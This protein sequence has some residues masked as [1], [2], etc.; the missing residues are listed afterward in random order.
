MKTSITK[1]TDNE[2]TIE[3]KIKLTGSML[4]SEQMILEAC[5][6]VGQLATAESLK[7]FDADGSPIKIGDV[8]YT[9][10]DVVPKIYE[11]PYGE[12]EVERHVYQTP[13]G[14]K[15]FCPL[16]H[17]AKIIQSATPRF[18]KQISHK[19]ANMNAPSVCRDLL[20]NHDRKI[21]HS[22]VQAVSNF[23]GKIAQDKEPIWEYD[24]PKLN[25]EV[26]SVVISLDGAFVLMREDGYREAMVG[27][28]SLYDCEGDRLHSIYIGEAPEYGKATFQQRLEREIGRIK[29]RYPSAIYLGIA[30]GAKNNWAF[31]EKHTD[32]QLID[33]FHVTEY[34][35]QVSFAAHAGKTD[36]PKREAWL[37]ERCK[38]LK[39]EETAVKNL[40]VEM[41]KFKRKKN[42]P[43]SVRVNLEATLTYFSN[44]CHRMDYVNHSLQQ[45]PIGS[46][47]TEAA[48]KTL[49]KQRLCCSGMRWKIR[50]AKTVL[51]LRSLIQ[52][53][54]WEQFWQKIDQFQGATVH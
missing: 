52:S 1:H 11:T 51:S 47:V 24:L 22:Y 3:V 44:N 53:D 16:E 49:V 19:Y 21:A 30:D 29:K 12:I 23:V 38:Q 26:A 50:G 17:A 5:N 20:E 7:R 39:H 2:L 8:K 54:Y 6:Q 33:F 4:E 10:R 36:K 15:I 18:A 35:A 25:Q 45:L 42:L 41:E 9:S 27:A 13:K 28:I 32:A 40:M 37:H 43:A 14:G 31:L 46:G 48:C 34:L